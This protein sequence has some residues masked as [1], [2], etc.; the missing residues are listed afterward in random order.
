MAP[1]QA[2]SFA[3]IIAGTVEMARL[4]AGTSNYLT[5]K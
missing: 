3:T 4:A 1:L 2:I 5:F